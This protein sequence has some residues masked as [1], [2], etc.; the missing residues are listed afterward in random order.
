MTT[1]PLSSLKALVAASTPAPWV[2]CKAKG[3]RC[4][5][6]S[7]RLEAAALGRTHYEGRPCAACGETLRYTVSR[8]CVACTKVN[9][10][11]DRRR[12]RT[13]MAKAK[14]GEEE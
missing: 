10:E 13:L 3:G 11:K 6:K 12:I 7:A 8:N 4:P 9:A 14:S 5:Q 2:R 1:L